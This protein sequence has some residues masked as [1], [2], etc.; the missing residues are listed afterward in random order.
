[1]PAVAYEGRIPSSTDPEVVTAVDDGKLR[2]L[3]DELL[4]FPGGFTVNPKL[5]RDSERKL[6]DLRPSTVGFGHGPVLN[7]N[8][9]SKLSDFV[10]GL[11][12][13]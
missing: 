5:N 6:A 4:T 9:A 1:M 7:E 3:N 12:A 2:A 10:A 8:A 13:G 11:P